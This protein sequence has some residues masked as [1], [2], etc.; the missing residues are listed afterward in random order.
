MKTNTVEQ[1]PKIFT[2]GGAVARQ[3]TV[4]NQLRRSV[5]SC[6]LWES[7]YYESGKTIANRI[8][9]LS[10]LVD[11]QSLSEIIIEART[12]HGIRHAPLLMLLSLIKRGV[13]QV[14]P[15]IAATMKRADDMTELVSLYM[16]ANP[17]KDLSKQMKRGLAKAFTQFNEYQL[18]KYDRDGKILL[19]DVL[20]LVHPKPLDEAMS[21]L[22]DRVNNR[23]MA[24]PDTW[25]TALSRGDDKKETFTRL[26]L[27]TLEDGPEG[28]GYMGVLRNLRNM[29]QAG[30]DIGL[31]SAV[32]RA[33]KGARWVFPF[34]YTAAARAVPQLE[35]VID[36]ALLDA[37]SEMPVLKGRT[38]ILVDVSH[39]MNKPLSS[40]SDLTRMDAAATLASVFNGEF[41]RVFSFS[42]HV[43]EV[44]PRRGMAGVDAVKRS[45]PHQNTALFDAVHWINTQI[46]G[47]DRLII[48]TDEQV[49]NSY[50]RDLSGTRR[51]MPDPLQGSKGYVINVASAKNGV[52]YGAWTHIDG[53]SEAVIKYIQ[54][55]ETVDAEAV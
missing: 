38:A 1:R 7:E 46:G 32:L 53:F 30:V 25:E 48:I 2:H 45:Q 37:V 27:A 31:I 33:R 5:M 49:I 12:V 8:T 3:T 11:P 13:P 35:P 40:K 28:M 24:I 21:A 55:I 44:P 20:R 43:T 16:L 18:A 4:I 23:T 36:L 10:D 17:G 52:G 22:F 41:L 54:A 9:E 50:S 29:V 51:T 26:L 15:T 34:R 19:R 47:Y 42:N 14:A 39:S 6:L